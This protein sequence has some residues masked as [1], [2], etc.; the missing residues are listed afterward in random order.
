MTKQRSSRFNRFI[1]TSEGT[2]NHFANRKHLSPGVRGDSAIIGRVPWLCP[3]GHPAVAAMSTNPKPQEVTERQAE[4]SNQLLWRLSYRDLLS[5]LNL[6]ASASLSTHK[7]ERS[8]KYLLLEARPPH[9]QWSIHQV[10]T[11]CGT[12][13]VLYAIYGHRCRLRFI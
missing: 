13:T 12:L 9:R 10:G 1:L 11:R 2:Q 7:F 8:H 4:H 6:Q 3:I 5:R